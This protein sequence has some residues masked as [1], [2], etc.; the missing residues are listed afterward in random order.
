MNNT[1]ELPKFTTSY[2]E[3]FKDYYH[4]KNGK[5]MAMSEV[6]DELNKQAEENEDLKARITELEKAVSVID[7][8][9]ITWGFCFDT[10][11]PKSSWQRLMQIEHESARDPQIC[12]EAAVFA[13]EQQAKGLENYVSETMENSYIQHLDINNVYHCLLINL[14]A[15]ALRLREQAKQLKEQG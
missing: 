7:S 12:R 8:A 15:K 2:N 10:N 6:S 3:E 13:L 11:Q 4:F 5:V 14:N 1:Q 9:C